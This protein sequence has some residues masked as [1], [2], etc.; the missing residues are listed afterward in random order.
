[1]AATT[2]GN[3]I[4]RV[5]REYLYPPDDQPIVA[6]INGAISA[7]GTSIV[8]WPATLNPEEEAMLGAGVVVE[9]GLEQFLVTAYTSPTLTVV[10]GW[11]GTTQADHADGSPL[12]LSPAFSR[13]GVFDAVAD[14]I[15]TLWPDL[16]QTKT[17]RVMT[18]N[19]YVPA[20]TDCEEVIDFRVQP[21]SGGRYLSASAE[22]LLDWPESGTGGALQFHGLG[23]GQSG[24]LRY[25]AGFTRPTSEI[26]RLDA[27][28][29]PESWISLLVVGAAAQTVS[30]RDI[31]AATV[32]FITEAIER[33]AFPVGA[34]ESI[35]N[36]LLRYHGLLILRAKKALVARYQPTVMM[37]TVAL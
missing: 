33:Q 19:G 23:S 1:M 18:T 9:V 36:A 22:L 13:L 35:R 17:A 5:Y 4:D 11:N 2:V 27:L 24:V 37:Q 34:G 20:P 32:E 16:W 25:K 29:V 3:V 14:Q 28:G 6:R 12:Y 8:V 15:T 21:S 7:G 10:P 31:D 30:G 26:Q